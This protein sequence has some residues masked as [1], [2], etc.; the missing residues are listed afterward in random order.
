MDSK[1]D[2]PLSEVIYFSLSSISFPFQ[3]TVSTVLLR[4]V[5]G[6]SENFEPPYLNLFLTTFG[7]QT[8]WLIF[9]GYTIRQTDSSDRGR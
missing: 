6:T 4:S 8:I 5:D 9:S 1:I 3:Q 2:Y 7:I